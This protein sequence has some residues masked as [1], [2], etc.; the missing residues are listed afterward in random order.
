M[1]TIVDYKNSI[2]T[3]DLDTIYITG[4]GYVNYPFKG[5]SR[6]SAMG[7]E[8]PV[9]GGELTRSLDFVLSN[10]DDVDFGLV[11]RCEISYKYMNIQDYMALCRI[12]KQRVCTVNY[13]NREKGERVIQEMAFTGNELSKLHTLGK[14][15]LGVEGV[16]IKLVATNRDKVNIINSSKTISYLANGGTGS[17]NTQNA[18]WSD[19][20]KL[21]DGTGFTFTNKHLVG[22]NTKADG[23]G[24]AYLPNQHITVFENL[25]L[26][27][28][29]E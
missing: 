20:I 4:G 24:W 14:Q 25:T 27:A 22:W 28:Q 10:I 1:G 23:S 3:E 5:I 15:Y 19:N 21:S 7:W 29:W 8:E 16:S 18:K 17:I 9:W 2:T 12:S 6:D 13:F 26:Y 11:A